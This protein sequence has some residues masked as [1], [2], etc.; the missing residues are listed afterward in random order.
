MLENIASL[1]E[2]FDYSE[3]MG[4]MAKMARLLKELGVPWEAWQWPIDDPAYRARLATFMRVKGDIFGPYGVARLALGD[5]LITPEE[6]VA[7]RKPEA[8]EGKEVAPLVYTSEQLASFQQTVERLPLDY[9]KRLVESNYMLV[10][11]PPKRENLLGVRDLDA[12]LFCTQQGGW[13]ADDEQKF[14]R[15]EFVESCWHAI[16]KDHVPDS[17]YK[18]FREQKGLRAS[19]EHM[20]TAVRVAWTDTTYFK[21]RGIR[22][23]N[24]V[25]VFTSSVAVYG[26]H[27]SVRYD[28]GGFDV[29]Y[30]TD[31][32]RFNDL[33]GS[34]SLEVPNA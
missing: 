9:L 16:R 14:S 17:T 12:S 10:A 19:D 29:D 6:I 25:W 8:E 7:K 5:D 24:G 15:N 2:Q 34:V 1:A 4:R 11:G 27:V 18:Y 32:S 13:Y 33:G 23:H 31:D 30:Y 3:V 21:V 28:S 26:D 22:L 20:P